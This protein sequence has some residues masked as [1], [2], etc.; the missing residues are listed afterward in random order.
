MDSPPRPATRGEFRIAIICALSREANAVLLLFDEEWEEEGESYGRAGGDW[1]HYTTGRIGRHAVVLAHLPGMGTQNAAA[2]A[3]SMRSS[4]PG[5]KMALLVGICGAVPRIGRDDVM[6]GD[7][8]ISNRIVQ[9]DYGKQYPGHFEI[10][11][12]LAGPDADLLGLISALDTDHVRDRLKKKAR[13]YLRQLQREADSPDSETGRRHR[14]SYIYPGLGE[15]KLFRADYIHKHD[16]DCHECRKGFCEKASKASC[17]RL[18]CDGSKLVSRKVDGIDGRSYQSKIEIFIGRVGS[19]N[20]VMK[21]GKDRDRIAATHDLIA[22]EMEG[23]GIL[24]QVPCIVIKGVCDYADSHKNK[25]WQDFAAATAASVMKA[26]LQRYDCHDRFTTHS[27]PVSPMLTICNTIPYTRNRHVVIRKGVAERLEALLPQTSSYAEAALWGLGG[28][29]KTQI[30]LEHAYKTWDSKNTFVFWVHA[31][32]EATLMQ[33]YKNIARKLRLGASLK[34]E[35]LLEAVCD[36]ME[37]LPRWS[38]IIDNADDIDLFG[39]SGR[40]YTRRDCLRKY[41]P[42]SARESATVVWTS[43]DEKIVGTLVGPGCGIEIAGMNDSEAREL[44]KRTTDTMITDGDTQAN[45]ETLKLFND[46]E[47]LAL[48][49]SQAG[50]FMRRT[51]M[52]VG[53]YLARLSDDN[54]RWEL[55]QSSEAVSD[56]SHSRPGVPNSVP[57]TWRI[58]IERI[59][60]ENELAYHILHVLSYLDNKNVSHVIME[61]A[62]KYHGKNAPRDRTSQ[63]SYPRPQFVIDDDDPGSRNLDVIEAIAKLRD[64]SFVRVEA[65]KG[66]MMTY[67]IHKLVQDAARYGLHMQSRAGSQNSTR[68]HRGQ[69]EA[70]K[71]AYFSG[72]A[73]EVIYNLYPRREYNAWDQAEKY[74][75]HAMKIIQWA[76]LCRMPNRTASLIDRVRQFISGRALYSETVVLRLAKK[77]LELRQK[78]LHYQHRDVLGSMYDVARAHYDLGNYDNAEDLADELYPLDKEEFGGMSPKTTQTLILKAEAAFKNGRR[79]EAEKVLSRVTD[80][81]SRAGKYDN[82]FAQAM[83]SRAWMHERQGD[84]D[85]AL[86][87]ALSAKEVL[88]Q[89]GSSEYYIW[90]MQLVAEI[91]IYRMNYAGAISTLRPALRDSQQVFGTAKTTLD[92]MFLLAFSHFYMAEYDKAEPVARRAVNEAKNMF[93]AGD[94][95]TLQARIL[96]EKIRIA[97]RDCEYESIPLNRASISHA[98]NEKLPIMD[99]ISNWRARLSARLFF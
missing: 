86:H 37:S 58:S 62:A 55:L 92:I 44:F 73:L 12:S 95:Q 96:L 45:A 76:D 41:I 72:I 25:T 6:L 89:H 11:P 56:Q 42:K 82:T 51:S 59:R 75:A 18:G 38:L 74:L 36:K 5:L 34:G 35:Q 77:T 29:G 69:Q 78:A 15:D 70:S 67:E 83:Y 54:R 46:L 50:T 65:R 2:A 81:Y 80:R 64:Y 49:I 90:S 13:S 60:Q 71:E 87:L 24:H 53:E 7:V 21:S 93:G 91:Y 43:R 97:I 40:T 48:P 68:Q 66:K 16:R 61:E 8:M 9:Y 79:K 84:K 4:F 30:A 28:S 17:S 14:A 31:D 22:F 52:P 26:V 27:R 3:A 57:G 85:R 47:W 94:S 98:L 20:T 23:A 39:S 19:A 10:R 99:H 1:N 63:A 32:T 33:D 88:Q